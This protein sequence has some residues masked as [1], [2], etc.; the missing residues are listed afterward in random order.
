MWM[1]WPCSC[2]AWIVSTAP[3][4]GSAASTC[5][6]AVGLVDAGLQLLGLRAASIAHVYWRVVGQVDAEAALGDLGQLV[7]VGVQRR[8]DVDREAHGRWYGSGVSG[9]LGQVRALPANAFVALAAGPD[10]ADGDDSTWT[11]VDWPS[12]TR[13]GADPRPPREL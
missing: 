13:D 10:Y 11:T 7:P 8:V 1:K 6:G 4:Y 12:L 3:G 2:Q 5:S 9:F